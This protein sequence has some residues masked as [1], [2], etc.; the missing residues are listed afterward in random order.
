MKWKFLGRTK[1][2]KH[3]NDFKCIDFWLYQMNENT[4]SRPRFV[5]DNEEEGDFCAYYDAERD[6]ADNDSNCQNKLPFI[7][8]YG[9]V[10]SDEFTVADRI[11]NI[12]ELIGEEIQQIIALFTQFVEGFGIDVSELYGSEQGKKK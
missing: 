8:W 7:C 11:R 2:P 4:M 10:N 9:I 12:Q 1:C 6:G 3:R 5:Y